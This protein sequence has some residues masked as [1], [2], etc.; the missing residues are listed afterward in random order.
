MRAF[1][2]CDGELNQI[3]VFLEPDMIAFLNDA[4]IDLGKTPA[5][6][7]GMLQSSDV[8]DFFKAVKKRLRGLLLHDAANPTLIERIQQL[9]LRRVNNKFS[10]AMRKKIAESLTVVAFAIGGSLNPNIV[11][12]GYKRTGQ[13]P[14]NFALCMNVCHNPIS[15]QDMIRL[16][17]ALPEAVTYFRQHACLPEA[18]M[19]Q[20]NVPSRNV[21]GDIPK[22]QRP[23]QNQR[24]VLF[25]AAASVQ[26]FVDYRYRIDHAP[27]LRELA[28]NEKKEKAAQAKAERELAKTLASALKKIQEAA[29]RKAKQEG[30]AAEK[31]RFSSLSKADQKAERQEKKNAADA[32]KAAKLADLINL[33]AAQPPALVA[34]PNGA[35]I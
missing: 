35:E 18:W 6:T 28:A 23:L 27:E 15:I 22:D 33:V 20:Q 14:L 3:R 10:S 9:L 29:D 2:S 31:L 4:L 17:A 25:N 5:S 8:S 26:A 12:D 1:V 7:S 16:Q 19:D 13:W 30:T 32:V 11:K 34:L 24:S 21:A